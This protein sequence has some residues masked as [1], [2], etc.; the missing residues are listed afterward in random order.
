MVALAR[1]D[2]VEIDAAAQRLL[3]EAEPRA[4]PKLSD[5]STSSLS[6]LEALRR[7]LKTA[8]GNA[9]TSEAR[10]VALIKTARD[11]T[12]TDVR[13]LNVGDDRVSGFMSMIDEQHTAWIELTS[14]TL[15]SHAEY[16][17][18]YE[19]CVALLVR[20]FGTYKVTN[21]QFVFPFQSSA[22]VLNRAA[23]AMAAAAK[24]ISELDDERTRLRQSRLSRWKAFVED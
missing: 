6:D 24:R 22:N 9:Q 15:A 10:Y 17:S 7:D 19:K 4:L 21:G 16:D 1:N 3:S 8:E 23:T 14:K 13:S 5:L 20:D 2:A 12:E 11:K 18:A